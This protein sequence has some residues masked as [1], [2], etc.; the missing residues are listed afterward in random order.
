MGEKPVE[1]PLIIILNDPF[2]SYITLSGEQ[3]LF[4]F[5]DE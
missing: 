1:C 3:G 4:F 2:S 5:G